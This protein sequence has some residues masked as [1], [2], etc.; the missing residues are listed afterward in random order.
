MCFYKAH[1]GST[2]LPRWPLRRMSSSLSFA[3]FQS[4][5]GHASARRVSHKPCFRQAHCFTQAPLQFFPVP[6]N[7]T[8]ACSQIGSGLD[9][10]SAKAPPNLSLA[11]GKRVDGVCGKDVP[12]KTQEYS[13]FCSTTSGFSKF[14]RT[15][16]VQ[17]S[18]GGFAWRFFGQ[19]SQ[20][21]IQT[22]FTAARCHW[23]GVNERRHIRHMAGYPSQ[24]ASPCA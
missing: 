21:S 5:G 12:G 4:L 23:V 11:V 18:Y 20:R 14:I 22:D 3:V 24:K 2:V 9:G 6:L 13:Y 7:P 19:T 1:F 8:R 17:L 16:Y 15:C 10:P